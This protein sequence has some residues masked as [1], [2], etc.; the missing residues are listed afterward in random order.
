MLDCQTTRARDN[1]HQPLC[2]RCLMSCVTCIVSAVRC[3]L[4]RVTCHIKQLNKSDNVQEK[5]GE[6]L[7]SSGLPRLVLTLKVQK[8]LNSISKSC[9]K[10]FPTFVSLNF[11]FVTY[12][13]ILFQGYTGYIKAITNLLIALL[14]CSFV[15]L[16]RGFCLCLDHSQS[17]Y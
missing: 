14:T 16:V 3:H 7:L 8:N 6:G 1:V 15:R 5:V 12:L 10:G 17:I 9:Q 4:S 13:H 11:E 2:A